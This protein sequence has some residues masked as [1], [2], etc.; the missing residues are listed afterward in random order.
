[1]FAHM[2][3][4]KLTLMKFVSDRSAQPHHRANWR[5]GVAYTKLAS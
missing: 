3:G 4:R 5:I 2:H 1:M